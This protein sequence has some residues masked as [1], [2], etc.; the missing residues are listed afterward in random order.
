M[1]LILIFLFSGTAKVAFVHHG[2]QHFGDNG[3]YALRPG[4]QNYNGNSYHRVLDSHFYYNIPV[5][6]HISGTLTSS[7]AFFLNDRGLLSR[8]ESDLVDIVGSVYGQ[9]IL[10][11]AA[12]EINKFG[13]IIKRIQDDSLIKGEGWPDHPTVIWI[14]ERVF[15]S[16][17][18]MPY[19]LVALLD[20]IYGKKDSWGRHVS[21]CIL[22]DD[23]VHEWYSHTFP[24]GT[25]CY[26]SHK[27]HQM[28]EDGHRVFIIFIQ[29][30]A[31]DFW[32]WNYVPN[33]FLYTHFQDLANSWDQ[34]QICVYGDDWEK[35]AG[36]AGWDFGYA[37]APS[38]SYDANI[39]WLSS[40]RNEGWMQ[41]IHVAEAAKWWG[42]DRIY[43]QNPYND[44][45]TIYIN[46]SAYHE[47]HG[48]TGGNYDN[49]YNH[50]KSVK[51][52][53][54]DHDA[55][56]INLNGIKGDY[57]DL[58]LFSWNSLKNLQSSN[59]KIL[60]F[61][62]LNSL[63]YETAWHSG[64][65]GELVFWGRNLWNHTGKA[66]I[67]AY[68]SNWLYSTRSVF[69]DS[70][71]IDGDGFM[72]Y[73]IGTDVFLAVFE[74]IGGKMVFLCD[75]S[76]SVYIG[77]F[78]TYWQ[79]EGDHSDYNHSGFGEDAFFEN[80]LYNLYSFYSDTGNAFIS[81]E[82]QG[83]LKTY[84]FKRGKNFIKLTYSS[85]YIIWSKAV[86]SPDLYYLIFNYYN[87]D[88][89]NDISPNGWMYGGFRNR[90]SGRGVFILWESGIGLKFNLISRVFA[91]EKVE[92]GNISGNFNIYLY[93]GRG[94]PDLPFIG[95]GDR[96]GPL[97]F[98]LQRNP[99]YNITSSDSVT[100]KI[101]AID[102]SGVD[103]VILYWTNN[104]WI[105]IFK[106]LMK[107][108]SS[109]TYKGIISPHPNGTKIIYTIY[110]KDSSYNISWLNRND[111]F[112]V[113]KLNFVMDGKLD[114]GVPLIAENPQ[115]H[116]W[117]F[118]DRDS[119]R[120]Y[121]ATEAA[122]NSNDRFNNDHFIFISFNPYK[123][124]VKSPWAKK[125]SV[126]FYNFFLADEND[127]SFIS[128]F[129]SLENIVND[130]F[131]FKFK[132]FSSDTGIMEGVIYLRNLLGSD[133][134]SIYLAVG[135]YKTFNEGSLEWQVP[136][137]RILNLRIEPVEF[138]LMK[139]LMI[140][141]KYEKKESKF[142]INTINPKYFF[143]FYDK[144]L[145]LKIYDI[146]GRKIFEKKFFDKK[147]Q[148][149]KTESGIYFI[150]IEKEKGEVQVF[151][152]IRLT[153]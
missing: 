60:G 105:N 67:F 85:P 57:E 133:P 27:V 90:K 8:L 121:I 124:I 15:K 9:N 110:A 107:K 68:A 40:A 77:N 115:M 109:Y 104:N 86:F 103:S 5:D 98:D 45:P 123:K 28:I 140:E 23:N 130:T 81:F 25:P 32:V 128:F 55:P 88:F 116:L 93:A 59:L 47:L 69:K 74:R 52:Y 126:G 146:T 142:F 89:E 137:W 111:S 31:R 75:S 96:E 125:D 3:F 18:L 87:L 17:N 7:Y 147:I 35:A 73:V 117:G 13:F 141:E 46:Y 63:L 78:F 22:L 2:N 10:P 56:D 148:I 82:S 112:I 12:R 150:R 42:V 48:W 34:E 58:W 11:Y 120:L 97:L 131:N 66:N 64:P 132:A 19:S 54:T 36:V 71:D 62:T 49:W 76:G 41:P 1:V 20:S 101:K 119:G 50:F 92:I 106:T 127:N 122:G 14:P 29:K 113:G 91:G 44:P 129:D 33:T 139:I 100:V 43:D 26:N 145:N 118:Y 143:N 24:D 95:P 152:I 53:G 83:I 37:G 114:P 149:P 70:A 153:N 72:E 65:G 134:D 102:P 151:K 39:A 108:D 51:A 80:N 135:T 4:D 136:R 138:I 38:N 94:V 30:H 84:S 144:D 21:P 61:L 99:V 16:K 6:I 79:G